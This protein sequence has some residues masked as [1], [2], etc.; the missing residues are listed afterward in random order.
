MHSFLLEHL[1]IYIMKPIFCFDPTVKCFVIL[2]HNC[3]ITMASKPGEREECL[4]LLPWMAS[5]R[6]NVCL[7]GF[8]IDSSPGL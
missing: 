2:G 4:A 6:H 5:Q 8:L 7:P 1:I 3:Y